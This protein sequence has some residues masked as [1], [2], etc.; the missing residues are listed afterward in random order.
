M[1]LSDHLIA[2]YPLSG[3]LAD[4]NLTSPAQ[5]SSLGLPGH[6]PPVVGTF[7]YGSRHLVVVLLLDILHD[8]SCNGRARHQLITQTNCQL[9][10][11]LSRGS[12]LSASQSSLCGPGRSRKEGNH[13]S[14]EFCQ[15]LYLNCFA[16]TCFWR[17]SLSEDQI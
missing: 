17:R 11:S 5:Y 16:D 4:F 1:I 2:R 8:E 12:H 9:S 7:H 14:N 6:D 10:L 3:C 15:D 13:N